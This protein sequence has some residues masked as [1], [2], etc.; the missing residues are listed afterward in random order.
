MFK[1]KRHEYKAWSFHPQKIPQLHPAGWKVERYTNRCI[2]NHNV[3][4][5]G[6]ALSLP[7]PDGM[8]NRTCIV[9]LLIWDLSSSATKED[10]FLNFMYLG[11][12]DIYFRTMMA[13]NVK[14]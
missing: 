10:Y 7:V 12:M 2:D 4:R 5:R 13:E 8:G 9:F 1:M 11:K 3:R 14:S 6:G